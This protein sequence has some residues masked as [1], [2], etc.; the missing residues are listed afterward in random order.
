M[1]LGEIFFLLLV[2]VL[3][4]IGIYGFVHSVGTQ[5]EY[6]RTFDTNSTS[7]FTDIE[8]QYSDIEGNI[9]SME[10]KTEGSEN[11]LKEFLNYASLIGSSTWEVIQMPFKGLSIVKNFLNTIDK[12]IGLPKNMSAIILSIIVLAF[13]IAF[14]RAIIKGDL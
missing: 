2:F 1:R 6:N 4:P 9:S 5:A 8:G 11:P 3:I 7:F 12:A 14:L 13:I 10:N